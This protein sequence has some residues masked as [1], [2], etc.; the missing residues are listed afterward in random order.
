MSEPETMRRAMWDA[1]ARGAT[2]HMVM[3]RDAA[4]VDDAMA[5]SVLTAIDGVRRGE[6][7]HAAGSLELVGM[8]DDRVDS[9]TPPGAVAAIRIAR[10]RHDL[11][12]TAQRLVLRDGALALAGAIDAARFALLVLAEDHVFTLMQA[13]SGSSQLQPTNLAHFLTGAIASLGRAARFLQTVFV[14]IDR[15]PL[16]AG[17]L[18]GPGF[19]I[20]RD[21]TADLLGMEGPIQSTFD[22]LAAVDHF[23]AAANAAASTVAPFRRLVAEILLWLRADA[24]VIRL[25]ESLTAPADLALPHFRPPVALEHIVAQARAVESEADAAVRLAREIP[26][27]PI[28]ESADLAMYAAA[29]ALS[30]ATDLAAAFASIIGRSIEFNRASLARNAGR[31]HATSGDLADFLMADEGLPP[32]AARDIAALTAR[33]A[34]QEGLEASGITPAM[35]DAAALAVIGR[36]LGVEIERLGAYLAPRRFIEKRTVMGGPA[37]EAVRETL[38][39][40]RAYLDAD[41]RWLEQKRRRIAL[42]AENAEIRTHEILSAAPSG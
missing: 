27:G 13:W 38:S 28:G 41:R 12:A 10:A 35:I 14:E 25:D 24:S 37:P 23:I 22:A 20:D 7:S 40:E 29:N 33:Q 42:A 2:A 31:A 5:A 34:A 39:L 9:L 16:G 11:A 4:I 6:P 32:A 15:S 1:V 18:A 36:E 19:P 21:Q 17:A 26:L 30:G 3:L 8:F